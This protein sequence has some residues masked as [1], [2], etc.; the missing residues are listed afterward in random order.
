M[1]EYCIRRRLRKKRLVHLISSKRDFARRRFLFL[2]HA[3]PHIGVNHLRSRYR[4]ISRAHNFDF[5]ARLTRHALRFRHHSGVRFISRRRGDA[6]V[7]P[8]ARPDGQKR[9]ANIVPIAYV[10]KFQPAQSAEA[11]FQREKIRQRLARMIAIRKC[12]NHRYAPVRREPVER[13]LRKNP[14]DN[15]V[16][17]PLEIFCHVANRFALAEVRSR[18]V[19]KYRLAAE[20]GDADFKGHSRA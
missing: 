16:N 2:T 19:E 8:R 13:L 12:V 5:A 17:H 10:R 18:V 14:R 3:C 4:I 1:Q 15:S 9:M 7:C 20:A 11:F 6:N